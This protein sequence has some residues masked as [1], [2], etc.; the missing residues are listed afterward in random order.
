M[1]QFK[2]SVVVLAGA[3]AAV[4]PVGGAAWAD[5]L[6]LVIDNAEYR[7]APDLSEGLRDPS[8][9][10][11]LEDAGFEVF[12]GRDMSGPQMQRLASD[13]AKAVEDDRDGARRIVMILSGHLVGD[14]DLGWLLGREVDEPT[15]FGVGAV[16]VPVGPLVDL[17]G[18]AP[19]QAVVLITEPDEPVETGYGLGAGLS[20]VTPPQGV[21][22]A[23]GPVDAL[24]R[25]L[26]D[27]LLVP[28]TSYQDAFARGGRQVETQGVIAGATGLLPRNGSVSASGPDTGE[29][30]YW[31]ATRDM[32][33]ADAYRAYLN[34]YPDG[35]FAADARRLIAE[36]EN[37]PAARA[38]A[39][40]AALDLN[41]DQRRQIQRNLSLL[42]FDPKGIDG[43]FGPAT[44][45]AL[46]DWQ[47]ANRFDVTGYLGAGQIQ[48]LQ[49]AAD[50][51]AAEME[52]E[53]A[54][55]RVEEE[56]ADRAYWADLGEG[57]DEAALRAYLKR[58]PDGIHSQDARIR[59]DRLETD[60]RG[61]AQRDE[62]V[63]WE[64]ARNQDTIAS[65]Q[66]FLSRYPE[67]G[68]RD[69]ARA[70]VGELEGQNQNAEA[71]DLARQQEGVVAGNPVARLLV[72]KRLQ[73][74]GTEPGA[75]DG[76][77][78]DNTRRA[79]RRFQRNQGLPVT[80][81]VGQD[82]MVRLLALN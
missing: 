57:R 77:F 28:G 73:Q 52:R 16:A 81:Y 6:A 71:T 40:E 65:Y 19:G 62:A 78:D 51:R 8:V 60:R 54:A 56:R 44:R 45:A 76:N 34:R 2:A 7:S 21:A 4:L 75:A 14:G 20:P 9:R 38:E 50:A 33:T 41:R 58:Y 30:A 24:R 15:A 70:R 31:G 66:S 10:D 69:A 23:T 63:A 46:S 48:P 80:G 72:E 68:F 67:S 49:A 1:K 43:I 47:Q 61:T 55:R 64:Q 3:V 59:L 39:A 36:A 25:V 12:A 27:G 74:L 22:L 29:I 13:F 53:A 37:A 35:R 82:T 42:G 5:D 32:G 79:L 17:A 11:A 18:R 26:I